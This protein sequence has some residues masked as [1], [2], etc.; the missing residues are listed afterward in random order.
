MFD[1]RRGG[2]ALCK[3]I[4]N[5]L[6]PCTL[7]QLQNP[8]PHHIAQPVDARVDMA[9]PIRIHGVLRHENT[10]RVVLPDRGGTLLREVEVTE[11]VEE[12]H[13]LHAAH[14]RGHELRLGGAESHAGLPLGF[15]CDG[16]VV[17]RDD[18]S[19]VRGPVIGD[20]LVSCTRKVR[21]HPASRPE[22]HLPGLLHELRQFSE[23]KSQIGA[24]HLHEEGDVS[25]DG[26]E[27]LVQGRVDDLG[28]VALG[29]AR[30]WF[31][32]RLDRVGVGHA[33]VRQNLLSVRGLCD[34]DSASDAVPQDIASQVLCHLPLVRALETLQELVLKF[35]HRAKILAQD[36]G[37]VDVS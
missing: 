5:V 33:V 6:R 21:E 3:S 10:R 8:I 24:G 18:E 1:K 11:E 31:E 12:I 2:E 17:H 23:C 19:G 32:R 25:H 34:R 14:A 20:A 36:Q 28:A 27:L 37:V 26:A 7:V 29:E 4:R 16:T 35:L 15:P 22:V 30:A 13:D 9:A